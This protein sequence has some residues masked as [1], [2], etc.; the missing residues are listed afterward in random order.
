MRAILPIEQ[1]RTLVGQKAAALK[2]DAIEKALI[3]RGTLTKK[4]IDDEKP[5][6]RAGRV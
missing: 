4:Q 6:R 1:Q 2:A 3:K 5:S